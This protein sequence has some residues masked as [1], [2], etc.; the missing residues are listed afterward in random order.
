M[1]GLIKVLLAG[2][3]WGVGQGSDKS[4][5]DFINDEDGIRC[6]NVSKNGCNHR[7]IFESIQQALILNQY[8][9][10][11]CILTDPL[12]DIVRVK[13]RGEKTIDFDKLGFNNYKTILEVSSRIQK[14]RY[15]LLNSLN[16]KIYCLGGCFPLH[17]DIEEFENLIPIC[18]SLPEY[19]N[20]G[21]EHPNVYFSIPWDEQMKSSDDLELVNQ[22]ISDYDKWLELKDTEYFIK[23]DKTDPWHPNILGYQKIHELVK[24]R[25]YST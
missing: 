23:D 5:S 17:S 19:L 11:V 16:K 8:D 21:W 13:V 7:Y 6:D 10:I 15:E 1:D 18:R 25:V 12:R 24:Q 3:S 20:P 9:Y 22:L 4:I 2:D 14:K